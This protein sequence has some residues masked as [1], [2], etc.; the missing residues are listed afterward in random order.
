VGHK[1][2][3][4]TPEAVFVYTK[5]LIEVTSVDEVLHQDELNWI[6]GFAVSCGT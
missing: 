5:T 4:L 3:I 2:Q 6:A 1:G